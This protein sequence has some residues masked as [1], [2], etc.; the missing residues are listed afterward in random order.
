MLKDLAYVFPNTRLR[1]TSVEEITQD[2]F[3]MSIDKINAFDILEKIE[4]GFQSIENLAT[5][6]K[7]VDSEE[8]ITLC[9]LYN[10]D[11]YSEEG[12]I[13][14]L[15][16]ALVSIK[17]FFI[18]LIATIKAFYKRLFDQN[19]RTRFT[20]NKL[21]NEFV[22][23]KSYNAEAHYNN[24]RVLLTPF[25][26]YISLLADLT[27]LYN[28]SI[29]ASKAVSIVNTT[30][31]NSG[32]EKFGRTVKNGE[33]VDTGRHRIITTM[34]TMLGDPSD[35]WGWAEDAQYGSPTNKLLTITEKFNLL[36]IAA[37]DL[38]AVSTILENECNAAI[39]TIDKYIAQNNNP[40]AQLLQQSLNERAK[41][42]SFVLKS[43]A[44]FQSYVTPLSV[45]LIDVWTNLNAINKQYK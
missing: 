28:D 39:R 41:R 22:K 7:Y 24:V 33:I 20:L 32:V 16:S 12:I 30:I 8:S 17:N 11:E 36:L 29:E 10:I 34:N 43:N 42:S 37:E 2:Y 27:V 26:E 21:K 40:Q 5:L 38:N 6:L 3:D 13:D 23:T 4:Y 44:I 19:A 9:Q 25:K 45:Q 14:S 35:T 31:F 15:R 18:N 1:E